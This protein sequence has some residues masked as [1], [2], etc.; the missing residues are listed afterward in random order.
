M[1]TEGKRT[2][3]PIGSGLGKYT[4]NP[5]RIR[6]GGRPKIIKTPEQVGEQKK[7]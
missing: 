4:I 3:R 2:G 5:N 7:T 1:A 6:M